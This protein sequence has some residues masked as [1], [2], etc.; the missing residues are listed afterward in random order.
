M[1]IIE[2]INLDPTS[3][4]LIF[5]LLS[6]SRGHFY[7]QP[8]FHR[9]TKCVPAPGLLRVHARRPANTSISDRFL[10]NFWDGP[11]NPP[12]MSR[13]CPPG[14]P[15]DKCPS[16]SRTRCT[17]RCRRQRKSGD[18]MWLVTCTTW[19]LTKVII[20]YLPLWKP[21]RSATDSKPC[22]KLAWS[23]G[24]SLLK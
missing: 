9:C 2:V 24:V 21:S 11:G 5:T 14:S 20:S 16:I 1:W 23:L 13:Q 3:G 17:S 10:I 7:F 6:N 15:P 19:A 18:N 4:P 22:P 8:P 12:A